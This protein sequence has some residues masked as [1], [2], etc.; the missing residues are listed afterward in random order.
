MTSVLRN[1]LI[2]LLLT[3]AP[4]AVLAR[5]EFLPAGTRVNV[6]TTHP[7]AA[8]SAFRGM[9]VDGFVYRPV[10]GAGG[11]VVVPRGSPAT[12]QVVGV[13]RASGRDRVSLSLDSVRVGGRRYRLATSDVEFR[14]PSG[15][16]GT[17]GRTVGGAAI[18]GVTGG[19][20]GGGTGAA[21]G[22][23]T[24]GTVGAVTGSSRNRHVTVPSNTRIEFRLHSP[25]R[26][27]T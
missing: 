26:I 10:I 3:T 4:Q 11:R 12:L 5:T 23:A 25:A 16:R 27:R 15:T 6:R 18:G 24:G 20:I 8:A 13:R 19:L 14:G 1:A 22:A 21:V 7:V 2:G 17:A 9:R